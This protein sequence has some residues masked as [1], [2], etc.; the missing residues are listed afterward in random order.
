[1]Y[2]ISGKLVH[3]ITVFLEDP[4]TQYKNG[5]LLMIV[6]NREVHC[7]GDEVTWSV[8]YL[9]LSGGETTDVILITKT[10]WWQSAEER[11]PNR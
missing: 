1:M 5:K 3:K 7:S 8:V 6:V 9:R 2:Q 4:L 10:F 11:A